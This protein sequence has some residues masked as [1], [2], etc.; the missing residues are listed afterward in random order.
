MLNWSI[1]IEMIY[2]VVYFSEDVYLDCFEIIV[3]I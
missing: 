1:V 2:G 3:Y